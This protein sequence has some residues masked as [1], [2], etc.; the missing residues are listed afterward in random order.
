[1]V[2]VSTATYLSDIINVYLL[3]F[4]VFGQ[5]VL[6]G[7][8]ISGFCPSGYDFAIFL[9]ACTSRYKPWESLWG[10]SVTTPL[11]G[12]HHRLAA[13]PSYQKSPFERGGQSRTDYREL[14]EAFP[15][16]VDEN[17]CGW[18]CRHVHSVVDFVR[19]NSDTVLLV[20][21][22]SYLATKPED[23]DW[24]VLPVTNFDACFGTTSFSRKWLARLPG[25]VPVRE[26][27]FGVFRHQMF[28]YR[29]NYSLHKV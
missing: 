3:D 8:L 18:F 22:K 21:T 11:V 29:D 4:T 15:K 10:S 2:A 25:N 1:M 7:C 6:L 13:C 19:D 26:N 5:L 17:G 27:G 14:H 20:L 28:V 23:S 9:L 24:T 12:F 16:L